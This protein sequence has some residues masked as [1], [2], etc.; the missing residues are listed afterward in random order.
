MMIQMKLPRC[1]PEEQHVSSKS[2]FNFIKAIES[3]KL[4]VHSFI[5]LK[6]GHV[7][8]EGTWSPYLKEQPHILNSLSKNFTST[9]IGLAVGEGKLS[10][11]DTVLS[12]FPEYMTEEIEENMKN[13][14][15]YHL[16]TM[17]TGHDQDTSPFFKKSDDWVKEFLD[18]RIVHA[19]GTHF[20]YN[21]GAT[22]MLSAII[23]K[24]TGMNLIDYLTP[25]LFEPLGMGKITTTSCPKGIH[26]GG[27]GM[28]ATIED[29]AKFGLLY[30]QKGCWEGQQIIPEYWVEEATRKQVHT[31]GDENDDALGYGYQF[32][33]CPHGAYRGGGAFGQYCV[34]S[35]EQNAVVATT[36]G[37]MDMA[38]ILNLIWS[39]LLPGILESP[40]RYQT[41]LDNKLSSLYYEP[42]SSSLSESPYI[43]NWSGKCFDVQPNEAGITTFSFDFSEGKYQYNFWDAKG[44]HSIKIGNGEWQENN[45]T[46]LDEQITAAVNGV[47]RTSKSFEMTV[48]ILGTPFCDTWTCD[49]ITAAARI[50]ITRNI[51]D[52][53]EIPGLTDVALL[54]NLV[55]YL[56]EE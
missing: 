38:K 21:T 4:E 33:C 43:N 39:H 6:N 10:V 1:K 27:I 2:I 5:Y 3:E 15:V 56:V 11:E 37:T 47:W 40:D 46:F 50:S 35:P 44:K 53:S 19:P 17:T 12:F 31:W 16:L 48:R 45:L 8:A 13:L 18:V 28:K 55:G 24:V 9:A 20:V 25:R 26:Y 42:S 54:P 34:V 23:T 22:Y 41:C 32:W 30:L 36:S 7:I 52:T 51:R 29:I 14:K 49:F